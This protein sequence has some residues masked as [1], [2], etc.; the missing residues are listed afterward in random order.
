MIPAADQPHRK[1]PF[2]EGVFYL[3]RNAKMTLLKNCP[4]MKEARFQNGTL[5]K[6]FPFW[7]LQNCPLMK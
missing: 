3:V 1:A 5:K 4:L 2:V 7:E 6:E